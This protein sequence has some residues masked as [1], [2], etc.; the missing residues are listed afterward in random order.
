MG[1]TLARK[2]REELAERCSPEQPKLKKLRIPKSVIRVPQRCS[3]P[4][5]T[6]MEVPVVTY[7]QLLQLELDLSLNSSFSSF[8]SV[9]SPKP[10]ST[11]PSITAQISTPPPASTSSPK[12][13]SAI[14]PPIH[15]HISTPPVASTSSPKPSSLTLPPI[16]ANNY[17][18]QPASGYLMNDIRV[19]ETSANDRDE[20]ILVR[21]INSGIGRLVIRTMTIVSERCNYV[22]DRE[23][24]GEIQ[25]RT[26]YFGNEE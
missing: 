10:S 3:S 9:P 25:T 8:S 20:E 7:E 2:E 24:R 11:L 19:V 18:P 22:G 14:L 5:S 6:P 17:T 26:Y 13:S 4:S 16:P 1:E 21:V 23:R 12:P 15:A